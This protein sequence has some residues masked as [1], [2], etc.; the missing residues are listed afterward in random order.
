MD[1]QFVR[2]SSIFQGIEFEWDNGKAKQ[3][4]AKHGVSFEEA[5]TVFYDPEVKIFADSGHSNEEQ[6]EIALGYSH[7]QSILFVVH[8]VRESGDREIIRII[9]A[10]PATRRERGLYA[11]FK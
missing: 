10:R 7:Q 1:P 9:S 3:N 5:K 6:R 11:N 2:T 4:F 8:V